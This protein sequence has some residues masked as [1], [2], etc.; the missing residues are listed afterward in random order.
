MIVQNEVN[1][2][3]EL[4][5]KTDNY[6]VSYKHRRTLVHIKYWCL[7]HYSIRDSS[8]ETRLTSLCN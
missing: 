2:Q 8:G 5:N 7:Y 4:A 1:V 6:T 3:A